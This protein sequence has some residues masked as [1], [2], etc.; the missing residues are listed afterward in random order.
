VL[1]AEQVS[2]VAFW[3]N[4]DFY[5]LNLT[6]LADAAA[7]DH[8]SQPVVGYVDPSS[9]LAT[10][11]ADLTIDFTSDAPERLHDMSLPF[12][13]V[14]ARTSLCHGLALWFDVAFDG[15]AQRVVLN[16]GPYHPGTHWYQCRLLLREPL[17]VNAGQ[18]VRGTLHMAANEK[19]SYNLT[20][21]MTLAGSE[22]TTASGQPITSEVAVNLQDQMYHYLTAPAATAATQ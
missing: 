13:F 4:T 12:E 11:T 7:K 10:T 21:S 5:G 18:R 17:A 1:W 3:H 2:K 8:F 19:Y 22:A 16:T 15:S 9:L 6:S 14:I 20:L